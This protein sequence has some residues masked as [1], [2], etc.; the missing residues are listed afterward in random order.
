MDYC[1][2]DSVTIKANRW[3]MHRE[4]KEYGGSMNTLVNNRAYK[5]IT[6]GEE[7]SV[8]TDIDSVNMN[9]AKEERGRKIY[10]IDG[11]EIN[12]VNNCYG[13]IY[14]RDGKKHSAR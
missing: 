9:N 1:I 2:S 12:S 13:G 14:I 4:S 11:I 6:I 3:I 10:T 5:I 7:S 8:I